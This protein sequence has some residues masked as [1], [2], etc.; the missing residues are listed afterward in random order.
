M[1]IRTYVAQKK[2][3]RRNGRFLWKDS[4]V[5]ITKS[6]MDAF[7]E[8][9]HPRDPKGTTTGGQFASKT[10]APSKPKA[11]APDTDALLEKETK[12]NTAERAKLRKAL[13]FETDPMKKDAIRI[14]IMGSFKKE[15]DR[16][17][18]AVLLEH[19]AKYSEI[20]GLPN[21]TAGVA[22]SPK[23]VPESVRA[24]GD[25]FN[26]VFV[27]D[28]NDPL[29]NLSGNSKDPFGVRNQKWSDD[30][31]QLITE[32]SGL[33]DFDEHK[34]Y[35]G[36]FVARARTQKTNSK[37]LTMSDI[38]YIHAYTG[39]GYKK[40]NSEL[41][42]GTI[43]NQVHDYSDRLNDVLDKIPDHTG[44]MTRKT[45]LTK[46]QWSLYV[47][48]EVVVEPSFTSSSKK[49]KIGNFPDYA[50]PHTFKIK[51]LHGKDISEYSVYKREEAE[52]L[53]RKNS[54]FRVISRNSETGVIE[55]EE[56]DVGAKTKK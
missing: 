27:P 15:Y 53:F 35:P 18:K 33:K 20:Y 54:S 6:A 45:R 50:Y 28:P 7:S 11:P 43:T 42:K 16:T 1:S 12:G 47:P 44:E 4:D 21:P 26:K 19:M 9:D 25:I 32:L 51:S 14:K 52:I 37:N 55:L 31:A 39:S 24:K 22:L 30:E 13:K 36:M 38:A 40:V 41:R 10:A 2:F 23:L 3:E 5:Q 46:D 34:D 49:T 17:G 56:V 8:A 29:H 48:G